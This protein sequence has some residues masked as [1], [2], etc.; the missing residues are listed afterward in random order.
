MKKT[1]EPNPHEAKWVSEHAIPRVRDR[2][3]VTMNGIGTGTVTGYFEQEGYQG[4]SVELD[5]PLF[6]GGKLHP[7]VYVFGSECEPTNRK[8]LFPPRFIHAVAQAQQS[9]P[10]DFAE[11]I[12]AAWYSGDY[13]VEGLE[14]SRSV[15]QSLRNSPRGHEFLEW[16]SNS[17]HY[18]GVTDLGFGERKEF[19]QRLDGFVNEPLH[20]QGSCDVTALTED[21]RNRLVSV[22]GALDLNGSENLTLSN[23]KSVDSYIWAANAKRLRLPLLESCY[24]LWATGAENLFMPSLQIIKGYFCADDTKNLSA[25]KLQSVGNYIQAEDS[26]SLSLP[27]LQNV[28]GGI[29]GRDACN[30]TIPVQLAMEK[31]VDLD[32]LSE[33][34]LQQAAQAE[35]EVKTARTQNKGVK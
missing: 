32:C 4:I 3:N 18:K 35:Q 10:S 7:E 11:R 6:N 2:V 29:C 20:I 34:T 27:N 28:G 16:F 17:E 15:L 22:S 21:E 31:G 9:H 33:T 8:C 30:L 5:L 19:A 23:L 25:P 24:N 12:H 1:N 14:N 13:W 26:I